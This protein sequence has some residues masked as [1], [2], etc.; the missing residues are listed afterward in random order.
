MVTALTK[1]TSTKPTVSSSGFA[2][3]G[4]TFNTYYLNDD[5][6][7]LLRLFILKELVKKN[8]LVVLGVLLI[9]VWEKL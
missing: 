8:I 5:G 2:I 7:G 3:S 1:G 4:D 9:I 6:A